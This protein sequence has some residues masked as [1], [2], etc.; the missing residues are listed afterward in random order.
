MFDLFRAG[1][2]L[3]SAGELFALGADLLLLNLQVLA[4]RVQT[5]HGAACFGFRGFAG[6]ESLGRAAAGRAGRGRGR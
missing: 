2:T 3:R 1:Q 5:L 4:H 6:A